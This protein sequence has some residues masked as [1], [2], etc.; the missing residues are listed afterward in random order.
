MG[1]NADKRMCSSIT[2]GRVMI[3]HRKPLYTLWKIIRKEFGGLK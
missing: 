2:L 1:T 3:T